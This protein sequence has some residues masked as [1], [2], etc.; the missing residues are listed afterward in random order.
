MQR[1]NV[2]L[3]VANRFVLPE[4][5]EF[6]VSWECSYMN[7]R[8]IPW[9]MFLYV[10]SSFYNKHSHLHVN[11]G[12]WSS[13]FHSKKQYS[14][15][16]FFR[17]CRILVGNL[18]IFLTLGIIINV[19]HYTNLYDMAYFIKFRHLQYSALVGGAAGRNCGLKNSITKMKF[20]K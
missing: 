14:W 11:C 13:W 18:S 2:L 4:C 7:S 15:L 3:F 16:S 5:T 9:N 10:Y 1:L 17:V 6:H 12:W 19:I 20:L 8:R